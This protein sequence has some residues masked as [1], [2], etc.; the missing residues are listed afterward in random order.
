MTG[1]S[2]NPRGAR[3]SRAPRLGVAAFLCAAVALGASDGVMA[4]SR[5]AAQDSANTAAVNPFLPPGAGAAAGRSAN[6]R[7]DAAAAN[8]M[9]CEVLLARVSAR[10]ELQPPQK[11]QAEDCAIQ[12]RIRKQGQLMASVDEFGERLRG[13]AAVGRSGGLLLFRLG[14][15]PYRA[16]IGKVASFEGRELMV[17]MSGTTVELRLP[18]EVAKEVGFSRPIIVWRGAVGMRRSVQAGPG[19]DGAGAANAHAANPPQASQAG[20]PR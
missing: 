10:Q 20:R 16:E 8:E 13:L 15:V 17:A 4:Q 11:A 12:A 2:Q 7:D 6:G 9:K 1:K 19:S 3:L 14:D 18:E 5:S